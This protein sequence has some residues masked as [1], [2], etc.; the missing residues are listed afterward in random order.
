MAKYKQSN[1]ITQCKML[2]A[3]FKKVVW[4]GGGLSVLNL[5][6][7]QSLLSNLVPLAFPQKYLSFNA[8]ELG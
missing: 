1:L 7:Y 6:K 3:D 8:D 4:K 5:A 2:K